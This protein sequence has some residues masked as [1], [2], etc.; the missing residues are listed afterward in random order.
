MRSGM[1]R[2]TYYGANVNR[3]R[4]T[5]APCTVKSVNYAYG[6]AGIAYRASFFSEALFAHAGWLVDRSTG[7][8]HCDDQYISGRLREAGV[9]IYAVPFPLQRERAN[10]KAATNTSAARGMDGGR[11]CGTA[12]LNQIGQMLMRFNGSVWQPPD[13]TSCSRAAPVCSAPKHKEDGCVCEPGAF[14]GVTGNG[15]GG[16]GKGK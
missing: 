12:C 1:Q 9:P 13:A 16:G 10:W 2:L 11:P 14:R 6:Y 5:I 3:G 4:V 7:C 8:W 15:G